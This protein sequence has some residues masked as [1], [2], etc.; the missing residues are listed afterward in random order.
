MVHRNH[1]PFPVGIPFPAR[2]PSLA[3]IQFLAAIVPAILL[4]ASVPPLLAHAQPRQRQAG[5]STP[6][7]QLIFIQAN[8]DRARHGVAPLRWSSQLAR[9]A[10]LHAA[11]M[12]GAYAISHQFAGEPDLQTRAM[13]AGADFSV[14][15]ENVA[16]NPDPTALNDAW[17]H[18][19]GHRANLLNP[20]LNS[21]GVALVQR[22]NEWFAV[23]D[24]SRSVDVMTLD[25][26]EQEVASLLRPYG[27][28]VLHGQPAARQT[29]AMDN[30]H[31]GALQPLFLM[32]YTATDLSKLPSALTASLRSG[33]YRTAMVGACAANGED[34]FSTHRIAVMLF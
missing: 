13:Q 16:V 5:P 18:S 19:P 27:L 4:L 32:H 26:Q 34:G 21:I 23:Q 11:R 7:E 33:R 3:R 31:A 17:M 10:T 24:F 9:A 14:I 22:G 30:G 15:A 29:C 25:A 8:E 1:I 6:A 20:Q 12:A 2:I 28:N